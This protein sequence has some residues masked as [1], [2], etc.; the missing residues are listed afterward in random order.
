M[1]ISKLKQKTLS[2]LA[3]CFGLF[4]QC[5]TVSSYWELEWKFVDVTGNEIANGKHWSWLVIADGAG[6]AN[7][8]VQNDTILDNT[9]YANLSAA[10]YGTQSDGNDLKKNNATLKAI[11]II[12]KRAVVDTQFTWNE[13]EFTNT[14]SERS[15]YKNQNVS[16]KTFRIEQ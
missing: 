6:V 7:I 16:K 4:L 10:H 14:Y 12:D 13:L 2:L 9:F 5:A 3:M 11:I 8:D 15:K 1:L